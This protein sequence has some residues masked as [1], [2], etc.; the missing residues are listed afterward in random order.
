MGGVR[1]GAMERFYADAAGVV[2]D[3]EFDQEEVIAYELGWKDSFLDNTLLTEA[4]IWFS[5]YEDMQQLRSYQTPGVGSITLDQVVNVDT[6]MYGFEFSGTWLLTD[7][8][9]ALITYSYMDTEITSDIFFRDFTYG[10]RDENGEIIPYN[11]SGNQLVLT[12]EHKLALSLHYFLPT[13]IG[14]FMIGGTGS[15]M[16]ERYFDLGNFESED[17]YT[18]VDLQA[19]WT[20][21]NERYQILGLVTNATDEEVFN[22]YGCSANADG[23]YGTPSFFT[24]CSGNPLDQRLWEVQFILKI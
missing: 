23:V 20:S 15:Y 11:V 1:L 19:S 14:E 9:R 22:T 6:E 2:D 18:R 8:L 12:P 13:D 5:D 17:S 3:G 16:D 7:Q 24:S 4:V 21:T 10:E